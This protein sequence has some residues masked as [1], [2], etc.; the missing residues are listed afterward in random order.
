MT[1]SFQHS[2]GWGVYICVCVCVFSGGGPLPSSGIPTP[3]LMSEHDD[4][5]N[6]K[7]FSCLRFPSTS[8]TLLICILSWVYW[9]PCDLVIGMLGDGHGLSWLTVTAFEWTGGDV[10]GPP[11]RGTRDRSL[12]PAS[13]G[14]A[15]RPHPK[16]VP[17]LAS[18][19]GGFWCLMLTMRLT[20]S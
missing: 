2:V 12:Y 4:W 8:G 16:L 15:P 20:K 6:S 17:S 18:G 5:P 11:T 19:L 3:G 9:Q 13:M 14:V 7:V 10:R 1:L